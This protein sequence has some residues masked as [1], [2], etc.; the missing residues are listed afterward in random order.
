MA[1]FPLTNDF[2]SRIV[3]GGGFVSTRINT[4]FFEHGRSGETCQHPQAIEG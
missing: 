2:E 1:L 4:G 3:N